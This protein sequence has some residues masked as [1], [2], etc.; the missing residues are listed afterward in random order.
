MSCSA[1]AQAIA[2]R[3]AGGWIEQRL[4]IADRLDAGAAQARG[5]FGRDGGL[6]LGQEARGEH[7]AEHGGPER[8][9]HRARQ[10]QQRGHHAQL[11]GLAR[12]LR[13]D[14]SVGPVRPL[15]SPITIISPTRVM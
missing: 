6:H 13:G 14:V 2:Q 4:R 5:Q 9:A 8:V 1:S 15:P 3:Q 11:T 10:L 7:A 12:V